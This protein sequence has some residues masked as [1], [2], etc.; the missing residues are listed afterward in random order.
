[1]RGIRAKPVFGAA[2]GGLRQAYSHKP[3]DRLDRVDPAAD[4][5]VTPCPGNIPPL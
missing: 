2:N 1:M 3:E 4:P 5:D